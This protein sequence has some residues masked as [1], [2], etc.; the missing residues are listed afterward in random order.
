MLNS[1]IVKSDLKI[2]ETIPVSKDKKL[3][4]YIFNFE[5]GH[6]VVSGDDIIMP[7]LGYGLTSNIDFDNIPPG[8]LY[9]LNTFK[10]EI[11][12]AQKQK[13]QTNKEINDKWN[14]YLN[15]DEQTTIKSYSPGTYLLTTTWG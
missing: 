3:V 12:F 13:L 4:Y 2:I 6:I 1:G 14:Y 8:L 9:L 10:D 5:K 7:V 15:L 11:L